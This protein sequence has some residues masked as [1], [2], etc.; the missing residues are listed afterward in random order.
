MMNL[1]KIFFLLKKHIQIG[2]INT[3]YIQQILYIPINTLD[4]YYRI[5]LNIKN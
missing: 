2:I 5:D 1:E 3:R 4:D